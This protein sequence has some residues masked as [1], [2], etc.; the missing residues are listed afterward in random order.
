MT[1]DQ[2]QQRRIDGSGPG[3]HFFQLGAAL[4]GTAAVLPGSPA[5]EVAQLPPGKIKSLSV[6]HPTG[7]FTVRLELGGTEEKPVVERA[8]MVVRE[9]LPRQFDHARIDLDPGLGQAARG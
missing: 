7:E 5:Y 4:F 1:S 3:G 6:E 2:L 9:V 8:G